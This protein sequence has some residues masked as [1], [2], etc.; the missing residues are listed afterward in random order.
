MNAINIIEIY[1]YHGVWVFDDE[2]TGLNKEAFVSGADLI[3][4]AMVSHIPNAHDGFLCIFSK[5]PFPSYK[6][7]LELKTRGNEE[8]GNWYV[9]KALGIDGWLCGALY[10]Y[11]DVEPEAIYIQVK[12]KRNANARTA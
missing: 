2:T 11:F 1:N 5:N 10:K 4:D 3:I 12:E 6:Y 7:K 9:C 8:T